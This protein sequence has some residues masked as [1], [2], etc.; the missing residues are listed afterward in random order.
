M[1]HWKTPFL[2]GSVCWV[3]PPV[4]RLPN[5]TP[6]SAFAPPSGATAASSTW[7][8]SRATIALPTASTTPDGWWDKAPVLSF[9]VAAP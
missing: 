2:S 4:P 6:P 3:R 1:S 8:P 9:G 7:E 5:A